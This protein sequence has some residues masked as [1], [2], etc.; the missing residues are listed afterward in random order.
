MRQLIKN[1]NEEKQIIK[2]KGITVDGCNYRIKF[3]VMSLYIYLFLIF[4]PA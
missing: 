2:E 3:I 1:L 4:V